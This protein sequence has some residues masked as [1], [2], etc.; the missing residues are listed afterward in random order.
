MN[1]LHDESMKEYHDAIAI[2]RLVLIHEDYDDTIAVMQL[3]VLYQ[4]IHD[5]DDTTTKN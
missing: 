4:D 3:V 2:T 5:G 1:V